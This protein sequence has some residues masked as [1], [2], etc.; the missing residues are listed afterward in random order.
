MVDGIYIRFPFALNN[1]PSY[2]NLASPVC[3]GFNNHECWASGF[4]KE[5]GVKGSTIKEKASFEL[6]G[7]I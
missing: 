2:F 7:I 1:Q 4:V 3:P 5:S 6:C